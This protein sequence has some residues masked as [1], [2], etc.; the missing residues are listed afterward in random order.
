MEGILDKV[1][2]LNN[3]N[4]GRTQSVI[5]LKLVEEV[6]EL[7]QALSQKLGYHKDKVDNTPEEAVDVV[8]CALSIALKEVNKEQLL[9]IIKVKLDKWERKHT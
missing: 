5:L 6:G 1:I 8:L 2:H 7:S 4:Q 9:G 3:K